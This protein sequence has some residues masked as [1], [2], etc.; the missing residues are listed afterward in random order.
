M[1]KLFTPL[2]LAGVDFPNRV[3]ISPMCQY[4]ARNGVAQPWHVVQYGRFAMGGA[5]VVMVEVTAVTEQGM[6]T[7]GDLALWND[8]QEAALAKV[9]ATIRGL[10]AVPGIQ[11][12]HAGRKGATQ[13]PWHGGSALS[14][15]DTAARG[16]Q[17]WPLVAPSAVAMSPDRAAPEPLSLEGVS[18]IRYAFVQ[19]AGRALR[20]GFDVIELHAAHGYLLNQFISPVANLRND[21]YG[22]DLHGRVRLPA[23]I[24][25]GIKAQ[26]TAG[27]AL[28]VRLS[29]SDGV[30]GGHE[31]ADSVEVAKL[32]RQAGADVIDCSSGGLAGRASASRLARALGYQVPFSEAIR[33]QAQIPTVAVGLILDGPQAE[34]VLQNE[35]ADL[36]AV[37]RA[38]LDD[39]NW[40][41]H[42]RQALDGPGYDAWPEQAGWWLERWAA[43]RREIATS[44]D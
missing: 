11:L 4:S 33:T 31:V 14:Q 16:E 20:A 43:L 38:A 6:G 12:G 15:V 25:A 18:E 37:G 40:P 1:S 10:G 22:G 35:A 27:Q 17:P 26:M 32:F 39:P 24:V 42:A 5:G 3:M 28:F 30:E 2:T 13:R 36:V 44:R 29:V 19:A 7:A 41:L 9:A 34:A 8:A 23:E 21:A